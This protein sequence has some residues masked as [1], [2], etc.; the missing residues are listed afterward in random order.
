MPMRKTYT[1][2]GV[3][4]QN[5]STLWINYDLQLLHAFGATSEESREQLSEFVFNGQQALLER[6]LGVLDVGEAGRGS[7]DELVSQSLQGSER[8]SPKKQS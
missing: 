8:P 5:F 2:R 3:G 1:K 6:Y 4:A 7:W